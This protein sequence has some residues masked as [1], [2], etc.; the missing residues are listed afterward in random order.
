MSSLAFLWPLAA[1]VVTGAGLYVTRGVL[2]QVITATGAMRIALLPPWQA[3]LGFVCMAALLLVGIDHLNAPRGTD[4]RQPPA[5]PRPGAAAPRAGGALIPYLPVL[6]DR[7]PVLQIL[8]GPLRYVVWL[9]IVAQLLWVLWQT[10][11]LTARWIER[12]S[13]G[14]VAVAIGLG[15]ALVPARPRCG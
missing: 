9:V 3:L 15:T 10:R 14:R 2:D 13:I 5:A 7:W 8:A 4:R 6:P 11:L 1:C 12:W